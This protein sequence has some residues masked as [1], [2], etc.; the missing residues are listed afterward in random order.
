LPGS[1]WIE[2]LR[3]PAQQL[4][5]LGAQPVRGQRRDRTDPVVQP[6]VTAEIESSDSGLSVTIQAPERI[7]MD[8]SPIEPVEKAKLSFGFEL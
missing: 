2:E 4:A 5:V 6:P 7:G 3:E 1:K 8:A